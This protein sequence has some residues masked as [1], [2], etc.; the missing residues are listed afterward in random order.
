MN[1]S[2]ELGRW[3]AETPAA[4]I[5]TAAR[6]ATRRAFLDTLGVLVA[7]CDEEAPRVVAS[8]IR[9]QGGT[10]EAS[11]IG[12]SLA[13]TAADAALVNGTSAH[14]LDWDDVS[15]S[16]RGHPSV[17]LVPAILAL[18]E[19]LSAPGSLAVDAY[20]FGFEVQARL[21]RAIG[22][23]HYALG[24]HATSTFG[25]IGAAAAS[26]RIL[27][28]DAA[29]TATALSIAASLASG[30]Q[31]NFGTMTKPFHAGWAARNGVVAATMASAGLTA[32]GGAIDGPNGLLHAASG[33]LDLDEEAI[34][35][36]QSDAW[37]IIEHGIGVKLYPCCYAT[38]RTIDATLEVRDRMM[39]LAPEAFHPGLVQEV[40]V[41]VNRGGLIPLIRHSP[42]TGLEGKFSMEYCVAAAIL[43]GHAGLSA[44][45]DA[46]VHRPEA[47]EFMSRVRVEESLP[48]AEF[49]IGGEARVTLKTS[50]GDS[51]KAEVDVPRGDPRRPLS[52]DE[53]AAKFREATTRRLDVP[54]AE[55]AID[56]IAGLDNVSNVSEIVALLS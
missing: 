28:L 9:G 16:L 44:F 49:P 19:K 3:I 11:V 32:A 36:R 51:Y 4:A 10:L 54:E 29:H 22:Q 17:P 18:G 14:A 34:V 7:G 33:G 45:T 1:A 53:L 38:H 6:V 12:H 55:R 21:G 30:L 13:T 27:G 20:V 31:A 26:A 50:S 47:R 56:A 8:W 42:T 23:P 46:M 37:D 5:P 15:V 41:N 25:T 48:P 43:D 40:A 2:Q 39:G 52:W 24:W 35:P